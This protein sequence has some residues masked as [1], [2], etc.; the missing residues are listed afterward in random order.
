MK[1]KLNEA[2]IANELRDASLFFRRPAA[3][4]DEVETDAR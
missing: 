4:E 3:T 1:K 2:D